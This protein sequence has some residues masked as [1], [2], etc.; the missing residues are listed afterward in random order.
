MGI[1]P[2]TF[3]LAS[4]R[5]TPVLYPRLVRLPSFELGCSAYETD[6][7]ANTSQDAFNGATS[8]NR[9][10]FFR[11]SG[12]R[13]HQLHQGCFCCFVIQYFVSMYSIHFSQNTL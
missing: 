6:E 13:E 4:R 9:T 7:I 11:S 8:L 2:M 1:E 5:T 3:C 12:G 10:E